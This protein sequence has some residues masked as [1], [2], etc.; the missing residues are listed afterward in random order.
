MASNYPNQNQGSSFSSG[1]SRQIFLRSI[2]LMTLFFIL[3]ILLLFS[4]YTTKH[5]TYN[6]LDLLES[7]LPIGLGIIIGILAIWLVYPQS[8]K[9]KYFDEFFPKVS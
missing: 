8:Y 2:L 5:S 6:F 1:P 4:W 3:L 9:P 7:S